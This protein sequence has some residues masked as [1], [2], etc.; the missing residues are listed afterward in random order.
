MGF[1]IT[2]V[3]GAAGE[4]ISDAASEVVDFA[5][6]HDSDAAE[7][8]AR[9]TAEFHADDAVRVAREAVDRSRVGDT[10]SG[11]SVVVPEAFDGM[12]HPEMF[13]YT[14]ELT[15]ELLDSGAA[16]WREA[17]TRATALV[18]TLWN[19]LGAVLGTDWQG[20]AAD[21]ALAAITTYR[22]ESLRTLDLMDIVAGK[23]EQS[24][25]GFAL[26]RATMPAPQSFT[27]SDWARTAMT[28]AFLGPVG[29][30]GSITAMMAEEEERRAEAVA[31]MNGTYVPTAVRADHGVPVLTPPGDPAS[32]SASGSSSSAAGGMRGGVDAASLGSS[33]LSSLATSPAPTTAASVGDSTPVAGSPPAAAAA[34]NSAGAGTSG[35]PSGAAP[36]SGVAP[37][38]TAPVGPSGSRPALTSPAGFGRGSTPAGYGTAGQRS[39]AGSGGSGARTLG[40]GSSSGRG[41]AGGTSGPVLQSATSA[42]AGGSGAGTRAAAYG[43]GAMMPGSRAGG[44]QDGEHTTAGYLV[45]ADNGD[46]LV[47]E[48]PLVAPPVI[49]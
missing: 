41:P 28:A 49:G 47:G 24:R 40:P 10:A 3:I 25:D 33:A 42:G 13:A 39:S 23:L 45:T 38:S 5:T 36:P 34:Q 7:S 27:P 19:D 20:A 1:D 17:H 2:G 44:D 35:T 8:A 46:R 9:L 16:M 37:V 32:G 12:S 29:A 15:P 14:T 11:A 22:T 31:V 48:L 43:P 26:T 18:W 6:G 30:A 21:S 4:T